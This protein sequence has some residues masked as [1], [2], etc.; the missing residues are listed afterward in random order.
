MSSDIKIKTKHIPDRL[1]W[2]CKAHNELCDDIQTDLLI[3]D[4]LDHSNGKR[5]DE[6]NGQR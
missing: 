5:H 1:A 4:S 2:Y 6:S 3:G